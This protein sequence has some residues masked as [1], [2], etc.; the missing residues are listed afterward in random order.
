MNLV[1]ISTVTHEI[2]IGTPLRFGVRDQD[3]NLLL[4]KGFMVAS[5]RTLEGLITRGVFVDMDELEASKKMAETVPETPLE[6]FIS[7]W[8]RLQANLGSI[9][10]AP[11]E[12][13]EVARLTE[14][15]SRVISLSNSSPDLLIFLI[16]R[17][18]QTRYGN[19]GVFHSLHVAAVC[20]L[21]ARRLKWSSED[22]QSLIGAGLTMNMSIAELQ[23]RLAIQRQ[24]VTEEQRQQIH[25]HPFESAA[26]LRQI[27]ITDQKWLA[28]VEQHHETSAGNGYPAQLAT[29]TAMSQVLRYIDMFTAKLSARAT[30]LAELPDIA[31]RKLFTQNLADPLA[32][33][34]IKE[35]GIYPPGC[36]VKL[37]TGEIA[38][39]TRCGSNANTPV[40]AALT[41]ANGYALIEPVRRDTSNPEHAVSEIIGENAVFVRPSWSKLHALSFGY[42]ERLRENTPSAAN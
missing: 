1:S 29:P 20:S 22:R 15:V 25:R 18:D 7:S 27:G 33:A 13:T 24:P 38:I 10:R 9:L 30:R 8:E 31:A 16:L 42:G 14:C 36:Y 5:T 23:G 37:A 21:V 28:A 41:N 11:P 26:L 39:V 17:H 35:F 6:A 3:G 34:V 4:A 2:R 19:Y 12:Q 32:A 40:V